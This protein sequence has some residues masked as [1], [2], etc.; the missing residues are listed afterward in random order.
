MPIS[1]RH[2]NGKHLDTYLKKS[3]VGYFLTCLNASLHG[4]T[5]TGHGWGASA[6][7]N[8]EMYVGTPVLCISGTAGPIAHNFWVWFE[9]SKLVVLR[10]SVL[11]YVCSCV[12]A[13]P[14]SVCREGLNGLR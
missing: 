6:R 9:T 4:L 11:G 14:F 2:S 7:A 12:R 10:K 5:P 8:L 13:Y 3:K 1:G